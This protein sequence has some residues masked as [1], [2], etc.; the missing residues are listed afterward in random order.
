MYALYCTCTAFVANKLHHYN[1]WEMSPKVTAFSPAGSG[2]HLLR[3]FEFTP[4]TAP[5]SVEFFL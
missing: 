1:G 4:Q 2:P 3:G 5:R